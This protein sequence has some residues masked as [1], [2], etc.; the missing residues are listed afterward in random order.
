[1]KNL[2]IETDLKYDTDTQFEFDENFKV[3]R[4]S[5]FRTTSTSLWTNYGNLSDEY[6]PEEDCIVEE[7]RYNRIVLLRYLVKEYM[8]SYLDWKD[9][10]VREMMDELPSGYEDIDETYEELDSL[11]IAYTS[12]YVRMS[13]SGYAQ[14]DFATILV[15]TAEFKK[16]AGVEFDEDTYQ[17]YF[18]HLFWDSRIYGDVAVSFDYYHNCVPYRYE[19]VFEEYYE[20]A[21]DEYEADINPETIISH[22][23]REILY[24]LSSESRAEIVLDLKSINYEDVRYPC[25]CV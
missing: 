3:L 16:M 23:E 22:I 11:G 20:I 17:K 14:G 21:D 8:F 9:V 10:S 24:P 13:T 5:G 7:S 19:H 1:M 4:Y 6:R 2:A 25:S 12:N 15:N 18:D